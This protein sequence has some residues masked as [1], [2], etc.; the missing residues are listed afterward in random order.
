MKTMVFAWLLLS[1]RLNTRDLLKRRNWNV[2]KETN[3]VFCAAHVY[4]E[5]FHLFFGCNF[6]QR[7]WNYLQINWSLSGDMFLAVAAARRDFGKPFFMEV[8]ITACW[9]IWKIRNDKIFNQ[10]RSSFAKWKRNFIHDITLL[11]HRL[12]RKYV[13]SLMLWIADLP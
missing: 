4:E 9:H 3:C 12:K 11:S 1:D 7:I 8:L 13:H 2:T 6:S 10:E 5:R